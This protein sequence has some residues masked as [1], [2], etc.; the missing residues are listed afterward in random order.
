M[1][2]A[3]SFDNSFPGRQTKS[4]KKR[5]CILFMKKKAAKSIRVLHSCA[6]KKSRRTGTCMQFKN[7]HL[8]ALRS[9]TALFS[10]TLRS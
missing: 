2:I 4:E 6:K 9:G 3:E 5:E 7:V 1:T 10:S 8:F